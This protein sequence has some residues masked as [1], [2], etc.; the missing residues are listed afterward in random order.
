[1]VSKSG[2][3]ASPLLIRLLQLFVLRNIGV[4]IVDIEDL[5]PM[6]MLNLIDLKT[7]LVYVNI[8]IANYEDALCVLMPTNAA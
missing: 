8:F 7:R 6:E 5:G 1:M 3:S 2:I 4:G